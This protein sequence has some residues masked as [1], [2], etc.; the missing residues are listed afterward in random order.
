MTDTSGNLS[1]K[2]DESYSLSVTSNTATINAKTVFG[3]LRGLETFSQLVSDNAS[4]SFTVTTATVSDSPRFPW[5]G[6]MIDTARHY[7]SVNTIMKLLD[8]MSYSKL[9]VLHWH[10]VRIHFRPDFSFHFSLYFLTL[11]FR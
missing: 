5:R 1:L 10:L 11:P 7:L 8:A 4:G 6:L 2:T 9:N 3:A